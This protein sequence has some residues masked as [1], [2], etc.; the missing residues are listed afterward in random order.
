MT[1]CRL[2]GAP[3]DQCS[4][5]GTAHEMASDLLLIRSMTEEELAAYRKARRENE[6]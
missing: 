5:L 1:L 2:C 3:I 4:R 6:E